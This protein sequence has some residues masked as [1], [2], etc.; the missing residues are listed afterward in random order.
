MFD[1]SSIAPIAHA[2]GGHFVRPPIAERV[3]QS[4]SMVFEVATKIVTTLVLGLFAYGAWHRWQA[5]PSRIT[6]LLFV[7]A[8]SL[9]VGLSLFT[10]AP[11][12][13]DWRLVTFLCSIG[14][15]YYFLAVQLAPGVS[16][17][18][19]LVGATLQ[20]IGLCWQI[21]AKISLRR[22]FGILPANRGVVSKGAYRF[23]RHPMYFG[24]FLTDIGFLLVNFGWQNLV[25]YGAQ[26]ALQVGRIVKEE[27][28][29]SDD[30]QYVRYKAS[31]PYRVIPG[32]F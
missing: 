19:Q 21:F 10:R 22:S 25:V 12:R 2:R 16:L 14:G 28:L 8:E 24:Y 26:F 4:L 17:I 5:D 6:L 30:A 15:S 9:S 23:I 1:A 31:V 29:L 7:V 27:E 3:S 18:P 20:V 11:I 13:R 32:V